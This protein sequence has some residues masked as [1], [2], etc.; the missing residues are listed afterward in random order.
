M[1]MELEVG[2]NDCNVSGNAHGGFLAWLIDM[3]SSMPLLALAGK[4]D[5]LNE[6]RRV[7]TYL[8]GMART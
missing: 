2:D 8:F 1:V 5:P 7:R 6:D 4:L 3:A